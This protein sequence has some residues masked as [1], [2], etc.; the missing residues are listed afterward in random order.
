MSEQEAQV[1]F[2]SWP[3]VTLDGEASSS[4]E[5]EG[6]LPVT[7][8]PAAALQGLGIHLQRLGM[9]CSSHAALCCLDH[10]SILIPRVCS[11][12]SFCPSLPICPEK[13]E[14]RCCHE[15]AIRRVREIWC[16]KVTW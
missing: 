13:Y 11:L 3:L 2:L 8:E 1:T 12:S 15:I 6:P 9:P 4:S 7:L 10:R 14:L 5:G 16:R